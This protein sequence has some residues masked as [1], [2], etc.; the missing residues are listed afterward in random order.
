MCNRIGV[1]KDKD[2]PSDDG[3]IVGGVSTYS[4][5][6]KEKCVDDYEYVVEVKEADELELTGK[7]VSYV[8]AAFEVYNDFAFR[9][10]FSI[11][12]DKLQRREGSREVSSR[13]FCCSKQGVKRCPGKKDKTF[14]KWSRMCNCKA[15]VIFYIESNREWVY[16]KHEMVHN[17]E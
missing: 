6:H 12:C 13:E 11:T 15:R 5:I 4:V 8:D 17:H 2:I 14:I 10:D 7:R 9:K 1:S 3:N 16:K